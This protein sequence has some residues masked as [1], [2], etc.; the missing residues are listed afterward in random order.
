M[1]HHRRHPIT[2]FRTVVAPLNGIINREPLFQVFFAIKPTIQSVS[3]TI[4]VST[5]AKTYTDVQYKVKKWYIPAKSSH[6]QSKRLRRWFSP[7]SRWRTTAK[8]HPNRTALCMWVWVDAGAAACWVKRE[9]CT[10]W[11][12]STNASSGCDFGY[13]YAGVLLIISFRA[14]LGI[15]GCAV[16]IRVE[17]ST[18]D[19]RHKKK[20]RETVNPLHRSARIKPWI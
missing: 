17:K 19:K 20:H 12:K 9:R 8:C 4:L 5:H 13:G 3:S 11:C 1:F 15:G 18:K 14:T 16:A 2:L 7:S 6:I 10:V